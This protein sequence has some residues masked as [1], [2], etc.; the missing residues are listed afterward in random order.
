[1]LEFG[2]SRSFVFPC[3]DAQALVWE[4]ANDPSCELSRHN[5]RECETVKLR[6]YSFHG[7][8][9]SKRKAAFEANS[10]SN[11]NQEGGLT[12]SSDHA[13]DSFTLV[14]FVMVRSLFL[15]QCCIF[16]CRI[17]DCTGSNCYLTALSY[18]NTG[19]DFVSAQVHMNS[20]Q[21]M[22]AMQALNSLVEINIES[23]D[24]HA[25]QQLPPRPPP[26]PPRCLSRPRES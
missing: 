6:T 1:M 25:T 24:I 19:E 21:Q 20:V 13:S 17:W 3:V 5:F 2:P 14:S 8:E 15:P 9:H 11:P 22:R 7:E 23:F 12:P 16:K 10:P 4:S 26:P 18:I